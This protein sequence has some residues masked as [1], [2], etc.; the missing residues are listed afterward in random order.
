MPPEPQGPSI[1]SI[2]CFLASTSGAMNTGKRGAHTCAQGDQE[3]SRSS[4][5]DGDLRP[6]Q[7]RD[8]QDPTSRGINEGQVEDGGVLPLTAGQGGTATSASVRPESEVTLLALLANQ[9]SNK[10]LCKQSICINLMFYF[11]ISVFLPF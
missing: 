2:S 5:E 9:S 8:R 10:L 3:Q 4:D 11:C 1:A 7:G 6:P